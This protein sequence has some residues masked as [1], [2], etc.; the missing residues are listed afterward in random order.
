MRVLL[1]HDG[2]PGAKQ[3]ADLVGAIAWPADSIVRVVSVV[4]PII[5]PI[6]AWGGVAPDYSAE[7][8]RQRNAYYEEE[9]AETVQRLGL[10]NQNA[11]SAI[12]RGRPASVIVKEAAAFAADVVVMGSRGHGAIATLVLGSVSSEVV[13]YAPCPVL[14]AKQPTLSRIVFA[15]DASPSAMSA[16]AVVSEWSIFDGLPIRVVSVADV[17][18]PW[19]T[20]IAPT[21]YRLSMDAFAKDLEAAKLEH[22]RI[23]EEAADKLRVSGRDAIADVR[24]GDAA[25]E[26]IAATEAVGADLVVMGSRGHSGLT[27]LLLGSVARNVVHGSPASILVVHDPARAGVA[28]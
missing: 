15:T 18:R 1:A 8:D 20:G 16:Q 4:E 9:M 22:T 21:M 19:H 23:A 6:G 27:R 3:A 26:V 12:L 10:S 24:V 7:A 11:E 14:V 25:G 2:S 13:D 5:A 17:P 28:G